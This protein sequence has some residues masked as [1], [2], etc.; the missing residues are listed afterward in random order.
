MVST[1]QDAAIAKRLDADRLM[2]ILNLSLALAIL[3]IS[4]FESAFAQGTAEERSACMGDA[5]RFCSAEIPNVPEIEACLLRNRS[6]LDPACQAEF[7]SS[8]KTRL[9]PSHFRQ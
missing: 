5:F 8:N 6:G 9:R 3:I 2:K 7:G 1:D 4:T